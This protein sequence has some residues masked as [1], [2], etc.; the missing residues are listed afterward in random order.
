MIEHWIAYFLVLAGGV[1]F[2]IAYIGWFSGFFLACLICLPVVNLVISLPAV[3]GCRLQ[4]LA[5]AEVER[6]GELAWKIRGRSAL[7]L[8]LHCIRVRVE[9]VNQMTAEK[10]RFRTE[11]SLPG[12]GG[13]AWIDI[14]TEHC[15]C[16][17]GKIRSA[18]AADCLGLFW[19][20]LRRKGTA[21]VFILPQWDR[22]EIFPL[23]EE[24][25]QTLRPRPGGGPSE[26]YDPRA[27][28]PGD[29]LHA[30]HWKL[31]AKRDELITRETLE[32]ERTLPMLTLDHF[33]SPEELDE[34]LD[35][36]MG[37]SRSLLAQGRPHRI[38]WLAPV[39]GIL[40][41]FLIAE[42]T[43]LSQCLAVLLC[44]YAPPQGKSI[45]DTSCPRQTLH[46]SS[47]RKRT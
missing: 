12:D 16:L 4:L 35:R 1:A 38:A 10:H 13:A 20:P 11:F 34:I 46:L 47:E 9:A 36:L 17:R 5:P 18:W 39:T 32:P 31:S 26:D 42:E 27:Y 8:P 40:Q 21:E 22:M 7:G 30:I 6:G 37:T 14:P 29:P 25:T 44:E 41:K 23:P 15:G 43:D 3:L 33:G 2:R 24:E 45:L 19:L 28:R